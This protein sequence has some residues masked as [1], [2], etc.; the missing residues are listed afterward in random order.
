MFDNKNN[1]NLYLK[2][3]FDDNIKVHY[4]VDEI[5]DFSQYIVELINKHHQDL[6]CDKY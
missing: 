1:S 6:E 2:D 5:I 4:V 3:D